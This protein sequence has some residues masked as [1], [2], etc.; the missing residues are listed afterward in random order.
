MVDTLIR[1]AVVNTGHEDLTRLRA[2]LIN[3]VSLDM[4]ALPAQPE[5]MPQAV[6]VLITDTLERMGVLLAEPA[7]NKLLREV[8]DELIGYGPLQPFLDDPLVNEIMANGLH[9][10]YI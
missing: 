4:D 10:I 3:R 2:Y 1:N 6:R 7:L 8:T 9:S 5:Q